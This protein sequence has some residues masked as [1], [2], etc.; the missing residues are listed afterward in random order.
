VRATEEFIPREIPEPHM[1]EAGIR[2][3]DERIHVP[4]FWRADEVDALAP[5][6][7]DGARNRRQ[8]TQMTTGVNCALPCPECRRRRQGVRQEGRHVMEAE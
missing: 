6:F 7:W 1:T 8:K 2:M 3:K 4:W 5:V